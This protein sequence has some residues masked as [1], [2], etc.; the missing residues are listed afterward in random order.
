MHGTSVILVRTDTKELYVNKYIVRKTNEG[1]LVLDLIKYMG[2][3]HDLERLNTEEAY[4]GIVMNNYHYS[5]VRVEAK[6]GEAFEEMAQ[7]QTVVVTLHD[8]NSPKYK[9]YQVML[10]HNNV[11]L[12]KI[13]ADEEPEPREDEVIIEFK[14]R[15]K[16]YF[17]L[18]KRRRSSIMNL[19]K[20]RVERETVYAEVKS[21]GWFD[22]ANYYK[23]EDVYT[24]TREWA[25]NMRTKLSEIEPGKVIYPTLSGEWISKR[26]EPVK[27]VLPRGLYWEKMQGTRA[28]KDFWE[29]YL[30]TFTEVDVVY[31]ERIPAGRAI[32]KEND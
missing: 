25:E 29:W 2:N 12:E 11:H 3:M 17:L 9:P 16:K 14:S 32:K 22:K 23:L 28:T 27:K 24:F 5:K 18:R 6:I 7:V 20:I 10:L 31:S 26:E 1:Q 21:I 19:K 8:K 4:L 13:D 15:R 30:K